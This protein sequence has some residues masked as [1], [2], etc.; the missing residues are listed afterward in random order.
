MHDLRKYHCHDL[1]AFVTENGFFHLFD[2]VIVINININFMHL[3]I[4]LADLGT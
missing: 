2:E 3:Y 4:R 1:L